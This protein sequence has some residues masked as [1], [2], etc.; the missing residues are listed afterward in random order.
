VPHL[1]D[2]DLRQMDEAWLQG[3]AEPVARAVL[4]RVVEDLKEARDR[5]N[6]TSENSSRPPGSRLPWENRRLAEAEEGGEAT[7]CAEPRSPVLPAGEAVADVTSE[8]EE[9]S[10][11]VRVKAPS[12]RSGGGNGIAPVTSPTPPDMRSSASGGWTRR[13]LEG[14]EV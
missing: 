10:P 7:G 4:S 12:G 13:P 6:Q 3:L 8:A 11:R 9:A 2:H 5:L 1:T 14:R